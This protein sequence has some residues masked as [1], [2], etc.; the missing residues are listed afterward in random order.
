LLGREE[1]FARLRAALERLDADHRKVILL[2]RIEKL[3]SRE[4]AERMQRSPQAVAQLLSRA[5]R[6]LRE[7]FG[8]TESL[9]L[10]DRTLGRE[11]G[12]DGS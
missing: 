9:H 11:G 7:N 5:L 1:R 3:P 8:R 12:T 2:A 10:P 6:K 4:I